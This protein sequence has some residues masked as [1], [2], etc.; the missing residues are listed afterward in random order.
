MRP[1]HFSPAQMKVGSVMTDMTL[2]LMHIIHDYELG[3]YHHT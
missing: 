1:M 2:P 3:G